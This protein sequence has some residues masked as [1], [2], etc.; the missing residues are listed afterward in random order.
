[1]L[2]SDVMTKD[3]EFI[4]PDE[5]LQHAATKMKELGIGPLPVLR[6]CRRGRNA[7]RPRYHRPRSRRRA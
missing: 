5:T 2:I 7:H 3:V 1:M 4:T 6:E